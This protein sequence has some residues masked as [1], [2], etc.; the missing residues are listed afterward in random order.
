M[1]PAGLP[2]WLH[3]YE[4]LRHARM[5]GITKDGQGFQHLPP[6]PTIRGAHPHPTAF[7]QSKHHACIERRIPKSLEALTL[8]MNEQGQGQP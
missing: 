2:T 3:L 5:W 4:L 8:W 7:N 1:P 6:T